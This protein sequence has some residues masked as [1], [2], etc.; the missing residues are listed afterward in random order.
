M[1]A[2][3]ICAAVFA[4]CASH[5][6]A[7][8]DAQ[9]VKESVPTAEFIAESDELFRQRQDPAKLKESLSL[10]RRVRQSD[11]RNF[12][13]AWKFARANYYLGKYST[14]EKE[15][16]KA[17]KDG[18]EAAKIAT[19]IEPEKPDGHFWLGATLGERAKKSPLSAAGSLGEIR[20]AM[21]KVIALQPDYQGASA[22]DALAQLEMNTPLLGG[23]A[24]KAVEY[25]EQ[26]IALEKENTYLYLHL[27][28]AYLALDK[29]AEARKQIDA[30]FKVK[31]H[32]DYQLEYKEVVEKAKKLQES[33]F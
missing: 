1:T 11:N 30:L 8:E 10:L 15:S 33:R 2:L 25:L 14:D 16:E 24:K 27:A 5:S 9:T 17:L 4:G 12:E 29:T 31:P 7:S 23:D 13:A 22:Y 20:K 28:E 26:A 18:I 32:P 21:E 6:D 19:R 3:S